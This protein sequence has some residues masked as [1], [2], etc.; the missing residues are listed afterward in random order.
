MLRRN[1]GKLPAVEQ[2]YDDLEIVRLGAFAPPGSP[3]G[4]YTLS[5]STAKSGMNECAYANDAG[6]WLNQDE[7]QAALGYHG[8]I[9]PTTLLQRK[10]KI[11]RRL[12]MLKR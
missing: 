10:L 11:R 2:H 6:P 8:R 5:I 1:V 7:L 9:V 12:L 3:L 4:R